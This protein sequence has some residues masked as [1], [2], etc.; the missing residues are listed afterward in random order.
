MR[1]LFYNNRSYIAL[2]HSFI[3]G[4]I[5]F[6]CSVL[7]QV[8]PKKNLTEQDY[9]LWSTMEMQ[10][11]SAKGD[12][13][14]YH[15]AYESGNDTLSV[16]NK[17]ATKTHAFAEGYDGKF[18]KDGWFACMQPEKVLSVVHLT[19]GL[20]RQIKGVTQYAFS[21]DG[22][23]L[24]YLNDSNQLTIGSPNGS[25]I[26]E[27]NGVS[28]FV[29]NPAGSSMVYTVSGEQSSLHYYSFAGKGN[30]QKIATD[31]A[32]T[33]ENIM[34][35]GKGASFA[36]VKNYKDTLDVRHGR[37]LYLYRISENKLFSFDANLLPT[38]PK[39][40]TIES[41]MWTRFRVSDDGQRVFFY[42]TEGGSGSEKPLVQVWNGNDAWT[43]PQVQIS[44]RFDK[45]SKC[46]VWWPD[47]GRFLQLTTTEQPKLMLNGD[48]K[49]AIT[50]N[51]MGEKPQFDYLNTTD[52]YVTNLNTGKQTLFLENQVCDLGEITPSY[53][54]KYIAY[55]SDKHWGVYE[56]ATG[57]HINIS[58]GIV[59]SI[60]D[61]SY[62]R[63]GVKPA[64]GIAGWTADDASVIIYDEYDL[65]SVNLK[66]L[67]TK[68]LTRGREQQI[69]F[70]LSYPLG[71]IDRLMNF[72]GFT[73][74]PL[75]LEKGL[76]LKAFG[77]FTK[78][79]G[80]YHWDV[81]EKALVFAAKNITQ[82]GYTNTSKTLFYTVQDF[83]V[84]PAIMALGESMPFPT[85]V[86]NSNPQQENYHW[87]K[88]QLIS[89][90]NSKGK[91]LQGAL[92]Y[93]ANYDPAKKYPMVVYIY[94][95][96]SQHLHTY[97]NPS[98]YNTYG[99]NTSNL[100]SQGYF[101]LHPDI[102]FEMGDVGISATDCVVS[103]TKA[104]I[105]M[106]LVLPNK[107][108]LH[109][110]SFGGYEADFIATQ[111]DI[112]ATVIAG[113]GIS[114]LV[115]HYLLNGWKTGRPEIWRYENDQWRLEKSLYEYTEGYLRNSP[116][117]HAQNIKAPMLTWSGAED[118]QVPY[119]QSIEFY[120]ALRRLGKKQ[121][122]LIYPKNDHVL[123]QSESQ[124]DFTQRYEQWLATYLKDVAAPDWIVKG[125]Q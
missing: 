35:Q 111:T 85:L 49:Y 97:V 44:G 94:E 42:I 84:P 26:E 55:R 46:A 60:Y 65:W 34:W 93:P 29:L 87:G 23:T 8:T 25:P 38:I 74:A 120:N 1:K 77:K 47:N 110:H 62:D 124:K 122:M 123:S 115:S 45:A 58:A 50:H 90:T 19:T 33:F 68:R 59:P 41:P 109:G 101:V 12:W 53:G 14:S 112:F 99:I 9:H 48:Q 2:M 92:Y 15:L 104:V 20:T 108:A 83:N 43:Y 105:A 39:A 89:Y 96:L 31:G 36:F 81:T 4:I 30:V 7:G 24:I 117:M 102:S 103:A 118:Q 75:D 5:F 107:I 21:N 100:N 56:I 69:V 11:V 3:L 80:Y 61:A 57:K 10:A 91:K 37:N 113:A 72:D 52:W 63:A 86:V 32:A 18:A 78:Q 116:V 114:D 16:R 64:Y 51:P 6:S 71:Q 66:D 67:K 40:S 79:S 28:G 27:I 73:F 13:V 95:K 82:L 121:I 76:Y 106:D 54:G 125:M 70:R 88:S 98:L 22:T 119:Y 17:Q